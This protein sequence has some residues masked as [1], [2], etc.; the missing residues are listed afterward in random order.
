VPWL[1]SRTCPG[2]RPGAL[3]VAH[4]GSAGSRAQE[5]RSAAPGPALGAREGAAV[6][7][8]RRPR[9]P[10]VCTVERRGLL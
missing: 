6:R 2:L 3:R 8:A 4:D 1:V 7:A 5:N 9:R 10:G